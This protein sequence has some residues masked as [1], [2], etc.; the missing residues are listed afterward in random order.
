[1]PQCRI[2]SPFCDV[3]L[4]TQNILRAWSTESFPSINYKLAGKHNLCWPVYLGETY[5]LWVMLNLISQRAIKEIIQDSLPLS[6]ITIPDRPAA[7]Q[8][9]THSVMNP[10]TASLTTA[11]QASCRTRVTRTVTQGT[12]SLLFSY[13]RLCPYSTVIMR[14]VSWNPSWKKKICAFY[15]LTA[16]RNHSDI[17]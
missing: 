15:I 7:P 16:C 14:D 11:F 2:T 3:S 1:M 6:L 17:T 12:R 9:E 4:T 5:Q 8:T 13:Q 10:E